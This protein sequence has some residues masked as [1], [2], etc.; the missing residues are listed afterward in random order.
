MTDVTRLPFRP[1]RDFKSE[2]I[3]FVQTLND[4]ETGTGNLRIFHI[5]CAPP[6]PLSSLLKQTRDFVVQLKDFRKWVMQRLFQVGT[7][8]V[9][10]DD[11]GLCEQVIRYDLDGLAFHI[12]AV[13]YCV[14]IVP[15]G[16]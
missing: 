9:I 4:L 8:W 3:A 2:N 1:R 11:Y 7:S 15:T 13:I 6:P 16:Y 5:F 14:K 10:N 12:A